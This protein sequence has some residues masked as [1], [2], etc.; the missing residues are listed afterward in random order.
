MHRTP[1][2]KWIASKIF[3]DS[4]GQSLSLA[5][6]NRH[7]LAKLRETIDCARSK[8]P[9]YR[10]HLAGLPNGPLRDLEDLKQVPF[11]T[12]EHL[13]ER[14]SEFLCVSQSEIERVVTLEVPGAPTKPRRLYFTQEDV[15]LTVDFFHHGMSTLVE[16]GQKV[17]VLMPGDRPASV[18]DLLIRALRRMNV[19][20]IV[21][22]IVQNPGDTIR[23]ILRHNVDCLVGIPIQV[24]SLARHEAGASIP[25]GQIKSVLLSSD[26]IS[27][28]I[29]RE[30]ESVWGC[31]VFNHYGSTEMGLGGG[32]ECQALQGYHLRE[33]DLYFEIVDPSSGKC[34][35]PGTWGE[36]VFTTLTRRGMPLIRYR[37]GDLS[38][39]LPDPCPCGTALRRL[40]RVRGRLKDF[41]QVGLS[42]WLSMV[43][44][45]DALFPVPGLLDYQAVLTDGDNQDRLDIAVRAGGCG[46]ETILAGVYSALTESD[47]L[48][49]AIHDGSLSVG[50][51]EFTTELRVAAGTSK[52]SI[53]DH[54][55][56]ASKTTSL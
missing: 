16:P 38:R 30:L 7:Q 53:H 24:F 25:Y 4:P 31:R 42:H 3:G 27:P 19:E 12:P 8:S 10:A 1:L 50:S 15:E 29:A 13:Q 45:D 40:D 52:R 49:R 2:D 51:V 55:S 39:F 37:T 6:V 56:T 36:I 5:D 41:T 43:D 18:G 21:H 17:L 54:R 28:A 9:F 14:G 46:G 34:Q 26:Y 20:G 44:L 22:G 32:V 47:A 48:R 11:T 23:E 35:P 33:A